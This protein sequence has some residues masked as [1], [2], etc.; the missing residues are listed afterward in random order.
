ML[1]ISTTD[2]QKPCNIAK[3]CKNMHI[4]T[5]LRHLL[6]DIAKL[7]CGTLSGI[8]FFQDKERSFR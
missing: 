2:I 3:A 4:G 1:D 5:G 7:V 8:F 6:T